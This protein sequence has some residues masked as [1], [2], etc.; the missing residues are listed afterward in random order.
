MEPSLKVKL[1]VAVL[2][3]VRLVTSVLTTIVGGTVSTGANDIA[4]VLVSSAP[5]PSV[6]V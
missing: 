6:I 2:P 5:L 4:K 3:A 1:M